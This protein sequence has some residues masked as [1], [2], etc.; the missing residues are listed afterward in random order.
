MPRADR[1]PPIRSACY[2]YRRKGARDRCIISD[3]AE[4]EILLD[5]LTVILRRS[6]ARLYAFHVDSTQLHF[7]ARAGN[8]PLIPAFGSFCHELTRRMNR[9]RGGRGALFTQRARVTVFQPDAWLLPIARYVHSI[10][11]PLFSPVSANSDSA[12]RERRRMTGLT[13]TA[14]MQALA[15]STGSSS[16]VNT[17]YPAY[18]DAP[19]SSGEIH[20]IEHGSAEDSR[21]LGDHE[22]ISS[23]LTASGSACGLDEPRP[24]GPDQEIQHAAELVLDRFHELCRQFLSERDAQEW[25]SRTSLWE[26]RSKSRK[27]P[28]PLV[29]ALIAD[30]VLAQGLAKCS[31]VERYFGLHPKSLAAGLRRRYRAKIVARFSRASGIAP[32]RIPDLERVTQRVNTELLEDVIAVVLDG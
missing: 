9:R 28:R 4:L 12:Y 11:P 1:L 5:T 21:I 10:H 19:A 14:I 15:C 30:Y 24:D 25:V 26:L 3:R 22:F 13:T 32:H 16:C 23:V 2:Y 18:F 20:T 8:S 27:L 6:G 31:D 29:R 7:V 17:D